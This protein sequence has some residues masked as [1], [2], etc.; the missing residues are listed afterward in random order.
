MPAHLQRLLQQVL[1]LSSMVKALGVWVT[2]M[3]LMDV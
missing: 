1:M 3:L 2:A